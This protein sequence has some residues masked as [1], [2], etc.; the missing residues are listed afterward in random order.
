MRIDE[1]MK[2]LVFEVWSQTDKEVTL[3]F[4]RISTKGGHDVRVR[5]ASPLQITDY[6]GTQ[7][8]DLL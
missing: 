1:Q 6:Y 5:R 4:L 3:I 7:L 2:A 8:S